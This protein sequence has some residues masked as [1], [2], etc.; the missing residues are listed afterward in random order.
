MLTFL[1]VLI[2]LGVGGAEA[3]SATIAPGFATP[4][5]TTPSPRATTPRATTS[6]SEQKPLPTL[7]AAAR[8]PPPITPVQTEND[9]SSDSFF[10]ADVDMNFL[11]KEDVRRSEFPLV[12]STLLEDVGRTLLVE[13]ERRTTAQQKKNAQQQQQQI[14]VEVQHGNEQGRMV[15]PNPEQQG[16]MIFGETHCVFRSYE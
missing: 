15:V 12:S 6:D 5:A 2:I 7:V 9:R 14:S 13:D 10:E 16:R 4:R 8:V 11:F 1:R 3:I